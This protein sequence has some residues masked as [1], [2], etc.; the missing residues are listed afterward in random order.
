MKK[1]FELLSVM[2]GLVVDSTMI[3]IT[4]AEFF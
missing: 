2:V 3:S 4:K 1:M